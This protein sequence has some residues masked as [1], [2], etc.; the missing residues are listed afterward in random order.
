MAIEPSKTKTI[1]EAIKEVKEF[2]I[3]QIYIDA[4]PD[5]ITINSIVKP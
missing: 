2:D 1:E 4:T 5:K 3:E